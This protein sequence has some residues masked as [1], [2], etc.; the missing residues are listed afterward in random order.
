M[1]APVDQ[2]VHDPRYLGDPDATKHDDGEK[3]RSITSSGDETSISGSSG[4]TQAGIKKVEAI[5]TAW[6]K[7]GLVVAYVS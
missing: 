3:G 1:A 5:S 2:T 6:S 7:W 4:K